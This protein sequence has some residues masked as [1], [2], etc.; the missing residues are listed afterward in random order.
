[1]KDNLSF[2]NIILLKNTASIN[3]LESTKDQVKLKHLSLKQKTI[4]RKD[5]E[6]NNSIKTLFTSHQLKANNINPKPIQNYNRD[7]IFG[8]IILCFFLLA[9]INVFYKKR[10]NQIFKAFISR[11]MLNQLIRNGNLFNERLSISLS[12]I[13]VSTFSLFLFQLS[14]F[15]FKIPDYGINGFIFYG[16]IFLFILSFWFLKMLTI[17]LI[18]IT[19]KTKKQTSEYLLNILLFN[20]VT[21]IFLLF[22][23]VLTTYTQL[24]IF[25]YLGIFILFIIFLYR[26]SRGVLI[27]IS[28]SKFSILHLFLYLCSVEIL[29]LLVLTKFIINIL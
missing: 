22:Y 11:R 10:L 7:W 2:N 8:I 9:R 18:G 3:K 23:L 17:K 16:K 5:R 14:Y 24:N 28:F 27:G 15:F 4:Q 12:F 21:G 13:F 19:F 25:L 6:S 26:I 20:F 1:M 29:P